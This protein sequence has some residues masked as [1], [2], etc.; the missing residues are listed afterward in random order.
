MLNCKPR[1]E[2]LDVANRHFTEADIEEYVFD[3]DQDNLLITEDKE[4]QQLGADGETSVRQSGGISEAPEP[5][6]VLEEDEDSTESEEEEESQEEEESEEEW[7]EEKRSEKEG[8]EEENHTFEA[9]IET[10]DELFP[11]DPIDLDVINTYFARINTPDSDENESDNDL[12]D[13]PPS[14]PPSHLLNNN[15]QTLSPK[16]QSLK[17]NLESL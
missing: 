1:F 4:G 16:M 6:W 3:D 2:R 9:T 10:E 5:G 17:L 11:E 12:L 7:S 15:L 8:S 13:L 14:K